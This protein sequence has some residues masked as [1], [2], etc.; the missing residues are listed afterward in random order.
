MQIGPT[1][2]AQTEAVGRSE[3][4]LTHTELMQNLHMVTDPKWFGFDREGLELI[5]DGNLFMGEPHIVTF[6]FRL[7]REIVVIDVRG[8]RLV[9]L[10]FMPGYANPPVQISRRQ[11][12]LMRSNTTSLQPLWLHMS[13]GHFSALLP[14][15]PRA[16]K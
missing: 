12:M 7:K 11:A 13:V 10:H 4:R 3:R 5:L 16:V 2:E 14:R 8:V 6:A 15:L 1:V 9:I